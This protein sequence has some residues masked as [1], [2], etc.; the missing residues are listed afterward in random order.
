MKK[1]AQIFLAILLTYLVEVSLTT[2]SNSQALGNNGRDYLWHKVQKCVANE[3]GQPP[4]PDPCVYVN[5]GN[6]YAVANGQNSVEYLLLPTDKITGIEDPN[7]SQAGSVP[8]WQY[9]WEKAREYI[10]L[11]K[12]QVQY[13]DQYGLAINS[14]QARHQDQLHIHMSCV[15]KNVSM[16]LKKNDNQIP[17]GNFQ[18]FSIQLLN[19][20]YNVM[21]LDNASLTN[22]NPF[23]LVKKSLH[24]SQKMADQSIAVVGRKQGGFYILKTESDSS[25]GYNAA[26]EKL[27][28]ENCTT[29]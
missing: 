17:K 12:S 1:Q 8:Y 11:K 14:K 29:Q 3:Q 27:L 13:R 5:L 16:E 6:R 10:P 2:I 15:D 26:A 18:K 24:S 28:D 25:K 9:A 7:V 21:R 4:K 23:Y 19:N 20:E 22:N